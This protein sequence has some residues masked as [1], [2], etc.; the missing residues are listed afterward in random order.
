[1]NEYYGCIDCYICQLQLQVDYYLYTSCTNSH[2]ETSY[3]KCS[4]LNRLLYLPAT[5]ASDYHVYTS[6]TNLQ[7]VTYN[8]QG[9]GRW[10]PYTGENKSIQLYGT[11]GRAVACTQT[12]ICGTARPE[13]CEE[14]SLKT[15]YRQRDR[16][17]L[18]HHGEA[19]WVWSKWFVVLFNEAYPTVE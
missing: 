9:I 3:K 8:P 12:L 15:T 2:R 13:N 11:Q 10:A 18:R 17:A 14:P 4:W 7:G 6:C 1:M 5:V 19:T 16:E